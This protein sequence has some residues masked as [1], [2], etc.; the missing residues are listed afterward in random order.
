MLSKYRERSR[1]IKDNQGRREVGA[2]V[3]P[4]VG[5]SSQAPDTTA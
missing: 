3:E 1:F 4:A 2:M 5:L